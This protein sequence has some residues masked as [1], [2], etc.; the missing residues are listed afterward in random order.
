MPPNVDFVWA[1]PR[2]AATLP[3][4]GKWLVLVKKSACIYTNLVNNI[5]ILNEGATFNMMHDCLETSTELTQLIWLAEN[6][7]VDEI[8]VT[9][10]SN[11]YFSN[12]KIG[13]TKLLNNGFSISHDDPHYVLSADTLFEAALPAD[14]RRDLALSNLIY[15]SQQGGDFLTPEEYMLISDSRTTKNYP[16]PPSLALLQKQYTRNPSIYQKWTCWREDVVIGCIYTIR[17]SA[18]TLQVAYM[19]NGVLGKK[20]SSNT[21]LLSKIVHWAFNE[22]IGYVDLGTASS[23]GMEI[24]GLAAYKR[25]LRAVLYSK[26]TLRRNIT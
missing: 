4:V 24:R 8:E 20:P 1:Q 15:R 5:L 25:S 23:N 9:L 16:P 12:Y 26:H 14:Q 11:I 18:S 13:I 22:G 2:L 6:E 10:P 19:A 3:Q 17:A 21:F 7:G